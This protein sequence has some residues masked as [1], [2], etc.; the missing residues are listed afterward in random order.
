M[1]TAWVNGVVLIFFV[2]FLDFVCGLLGVPDPFSSGEF[3]VR[4]EWARHHDLVG[5]FDIAV[6]RVEIAVSAY[7][8][9]A[10]D[11]WLGFD[12]VV[13]SRDGGCENIRLSSGGAHIDNV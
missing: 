7:S 9:V 6:R 12:V 5:A 1:D 8:L 13:L 4:L 2:H 10:E 3:F 11:V